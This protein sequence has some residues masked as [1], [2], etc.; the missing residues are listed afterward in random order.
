MPHPITVV[1]AA[2]SPDGKWV[3]TGDFASARLW[4][5][6]APLAG[7]PV[8]IELWAEVLTGL[9]LEDYGVVRP[10]MP[11]GGRNTAGD[12][13][14]RAGRYPKSLP[15]KGTWPGLRPLLGGRGFATPQPR[16][17]APGWGFFS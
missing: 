11:R 12:C 7:S 17:C 4:E 15:A 5:V 10:W 8:Q 9:E 16:Q 1:V 13:W 2:F 3:A 14:S 6:P